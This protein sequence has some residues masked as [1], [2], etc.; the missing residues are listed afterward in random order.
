M[1]MSSRLSKK[2][3]LVISI[4]LILILLTASFLVHEVKRPGHEIDYE[5]ITRAGSCNWSYYEESWQGE[6]LVIRNRSSWNESWNEFTGLSSSRQPPA[7]DNV[8]W[9]REMVLVV[10]YG[11]A[12]DLQKDVYF[13][14][15]RQ[16]GLKVHAYVR[17]VNETPGAVFPMCHCP[18][19][20]IVVE[21]A[22]DVVFLEDLGTQY[23]LDYWAVSVLVTLSAIGIYLLIKKPRTGFISVNWSNSKESER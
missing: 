1:Q 18:I 14:S 10:S 11:V 21:T 6:M 3:A 16:D 19:H 7:I 5:M 17:W 8:S 9:D 4:I 23:E 2:H 13:T 20:A 15:V 12:S 22:P